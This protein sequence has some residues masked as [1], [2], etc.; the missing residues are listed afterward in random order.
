M[1]GGTGL[2]TRVG[3]DAFEIGYWIRTDAAG[4][5][6]ATEASAA[7][8]RTALELCGAERVE[9]RIDPRNEASLFAEDLPGSP[10]AAAAFAAHD[11]A[12]ARVA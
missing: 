10:A 5:G 1:V 9:L 6:L 11:A 7:L 3:P 4:A 2:H 12:G 8:T